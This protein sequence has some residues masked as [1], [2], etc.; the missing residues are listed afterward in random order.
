MA[1][2]DELLGRGENILYEARQHVVLLISRIFMKLVL[3]GILIATAIVS[4]EAFSY[5]TTPIIAGFTASQ[6]IPALAIFISVLLLI[7][8]F[9]D[10]LAWNAEQYIITDRR[11]IQISGALNKTV[12]DS[13]LDKVNDIRLIQ[14]IFGRVFRYGSIYVSTATEDS[15]YTMEHVVAP[16]DFKRAIQE[17]KQNYER[18]YGY[19]DAHTHPQVADTPQNTSPDVHRTI[20]ELATLRDRGILSIDEFEAKKR[21]ILSRI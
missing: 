15:A 9:T 21:E 6:L 14:S 1:Y 5:K 11:L 4:Y 10:F 3:I 18:G 17:A 7:S 8:I 16:F 2:I 13:P 12:L 19:L 20:E